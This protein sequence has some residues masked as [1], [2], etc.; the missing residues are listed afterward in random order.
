M[1]KKIAVLSL[2][3]GILG[4]GFY[5]GRPHCLEYLARRQAES[6][7]LMVVQAIAGKDAKI[8][9]S[10]HQGQ[11][12]YIDAIPT[13]NSIC[14]ELLRTGDAEAISVGKLCFRKLAVQ[15]SEKSTYYAQSEAAV[16]FLNAEKSS[17][18][19]TL[20]LIT[21]PLTNSDS[22]SALWSASKPNIFEA[23]P[24]KTLFNEEHGI[25]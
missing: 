13:K 20:R 11:T 6:E 8:A 12:W 18:E 21:T 23:E 19:T 17:T 1:I 16:Y 22:T 7:S 24:Y 10:G 2:L 15:K 9:P 5:F 4:T 3:A 14:L 25:K